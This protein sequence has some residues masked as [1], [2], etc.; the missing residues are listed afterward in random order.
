MG[1][2]NLKVHGISLE[3]QYSKDIPLVK[4]VP[5]QLKQVALNLFNNVIDACD[6]GG[7]ITITTEMSGENIVIYFHDNGN[8]IRPEDI[9]HIFEPFFTTKPAVKGTGLGLSVSYGIIKSHGGNIDVES[10][11]GKGTTFTLTLPV[12]GVS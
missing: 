9:D 11:V 2:N 6:K 8:G 12:D 10:E 1:K 5:D 4:V 3:K 7:E